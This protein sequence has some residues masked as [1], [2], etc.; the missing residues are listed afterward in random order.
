[1]CSRWHWITEYNVTIRTSGMYITG[2]LATLEMR[3]Y[4]VPSR[5]QVPVLVVHAGTLV[6]VLVHIILSIKRIFLNIL[7]RDERPT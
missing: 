2:I 5:V 4:R 6:P 3:F 1:M 7:I